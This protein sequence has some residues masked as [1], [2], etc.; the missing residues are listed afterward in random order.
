MNMFFNRRAESISLQATHKGFTL[1]ELLIVIGILAVLATATVVILNPGELLAQARDSSRIADMGTM[2][3]A[4][5]L[6]LSDRSGSYA[7]AASGCAATNTVAGA[8]LKPGYVQVAPALGTF[9]TKVQLGGTND[10][11]VKADRSVAGLG[12]FPVDFTAIATGAPFGSLP[13]DPSAT[14]TTYVYRANFGDCGKTTC[15][16]GIVSSSKMYY[17]INARMESLKYTA[18]TQVAAND[19]GDKNGCTGAGGST[20]T[21]CVLEVGNTDNLTL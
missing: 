9:V 11:C 20:D 2:Q 3:A 14:S 4:M 15:T 16:V 21:T 19:G 6:Y 8:G 5:G 10:Q 12:W 1:V 18:L 13:L 7:I 17:E